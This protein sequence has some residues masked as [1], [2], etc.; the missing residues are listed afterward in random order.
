MRTIRLPIT[1]AMS[2]EET[3]SD[4]ARTSL[5]TVSKAAAIKSPNVVL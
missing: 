1:R 4:T 2:E 3:S 5:P